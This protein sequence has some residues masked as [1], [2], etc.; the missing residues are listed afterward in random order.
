MTISRRT[1]AALAEAI[2]LRITQAVMDGLVFEFNAEESDTGG[3]V[4][5]RAVA[6]VRHLTEHID[7]KGI[8]DAVIDLVP[9]LHVTNDHPI[10]ARLLETLRLDGYEVVGNNLI[11]TTPEPAALGPQ[12]SMLEHDMDNR[13][14]L[15]AVSHY[16]QAVEN[17][18]SGNWEAAN[19]QVRSFFE[20]LTI[21]LNTTATGKSR[22]E[23]LAALQDLRQASLIDDAEWNQLRGF[24]SGIQDNGPHHGLSSNEEA[25]FRLHA[26]TAL[27]RYLLAKAY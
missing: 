22:N 26:A 5:K 9:R 8:L 10:T 12:V 17:F 1:L 27:S 6:F 20:N 19:G 18:V 24:W 25:L 16:R 7:E 15:T 21:S 3:S 2:D 23:P 11:P 13:G 4:K 14:L